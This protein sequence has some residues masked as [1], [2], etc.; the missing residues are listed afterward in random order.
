MAT[1]L[2]FF[3]YFI[4]IGLGIP[5]S[6]I[7]SAWPSIYP[8]LNL[9][10][11]YASF[12]TVI[13]SLCTASSS[14]FSAKLINKFGTGLVTAVSTLVTAIALLGFSKSTSIWWLCVSS[15]PAGFGAGAI[16][17]ALNDYVAIRYKS[18]SVSFLHCF[19]GIG[20]ALTPFLMSFALKDNNWRLGYRLIFYIQIGIALVSFAVL[21]L[22][23]KVKAQNPSQD[24]YTPIALSYPKM[25]KIPEVRLGWLV[26]FTTCGL[27]F[28]CNTWATSFFVNTEKATEAVASLFLTFY[29]LGIT[30]GRFIS[31]LLAK[32]L[33]NK[34]IVLLGYILVA[35][36]IILLILPV[37]TIIK[38]IALCMIGLGNGP[39]FPNLIYLTPKCFGKECSRSIIASQMAM[40]NIGI[41]VIPM[42]FGLVA[43][44]ISVSLFPYFLLLLYVIIVPSML[45]YFRQLKKLNERGGLTFNN[46]TEVKNG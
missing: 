22:W 36:A 11:G 43:N 27:E 34:S 8:D 31:G 15:I 14:F 40:C 16:D 25:A 12:I 2:L 26:F 23:K 21:P 30:V 32:K 41:L 37:A 33:S 18:S 35:I 7:G 10:I 4:Y 6:A 20:V 13:I 45:V 28:S 44:N 3:I 19:Y 17:A 46:N 38:G 1:L 5:D 42:L 29:Y 24:D 9:P 39:S